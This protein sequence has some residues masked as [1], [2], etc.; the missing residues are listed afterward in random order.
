MNY[1]FGPYHKEKDGG[2][3]VVTF[4]D[5]VENFIEH[6]DTLRSQEIYKHDKCA[7]SLALYFS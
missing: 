3:D 1:M 4:K 7:G 6:V 2:R 5:S